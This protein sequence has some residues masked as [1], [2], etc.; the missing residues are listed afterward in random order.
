MPFQPP[1]PITREVRSDTMSPN[2]EDFSCRL[3]VAHRSREL[4]IAYPLPFPAFG[5]GVG[6]QRTVGV[7]QMS[8]GQK[9]SHFTLFQCFLYHPPTTQH[10]NGHSQQRI[11]RRDER[12]LTSRSNS[13]PISG[14]LAFNCEI[15]SVSRDN[16]IT[17][18]GNQYFLFGILPDG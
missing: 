3:I 4:P 14:L 7:L 16:G 15:K 12:V 8:V 2:G 18:V 10:Q 6:A 13:L 17:S 11:H 9:R 1:Q 5:N